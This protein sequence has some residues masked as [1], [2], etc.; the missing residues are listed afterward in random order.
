M[1][2]I[3]DRQIIVDFRHSE[4]DFADQVID[5]FDFLH[6]EAQEAGGRIMAITL[7]PW[8]IGQPHRIGALER[9]LKHIQSKPSVWSASGDD[10]VEAWTAAQ[11]AGA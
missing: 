9:A 6:R 7:H 11:P 4:G 8:V 2:E 3:S 5:Q 1:S 10:L